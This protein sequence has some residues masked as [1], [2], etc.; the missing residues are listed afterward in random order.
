MANGYAPF[1]LQHL[2]QLVTDNYPGTKV[3][4]TGFLKMLLLNNPS[5]QI[6]DYEKIRLTNSQGHV[7]EIKLWYH[8]RIKPSE[9]ST[10][11]SCDNNF[12]PV[13]KEMTLSA[14]GYRQL[15]FFIS[16]IEIAKYQEEASKTVA[17]GQPATQLMNEHFTTIMTTV[18]GMMGSINLDLLGLVT[19]GDNATTGNN[20]AV[21]IN[22]NQNTVINPLTDGF[23]RILN[24]YAANE[25]VGEP[26][27]VGNGLMNAFQL[28]K[29]YA[30]P[31]MNGVDLSKIG[32]YQWYYDLYTTTPW[33]GANNIGVFSPGSIGFVDLNQYVG[34]RAK[35]LG[36]STYFQIQLPVVPAQNDGTAELMTFDAQLKEIDC[37]TEVYDSN[38]GGVRTVKEG[39]QLIISKSYGLFQLPADAYQTGDR[40]EGN[41]GALRY[42]IT[43]DCTECEAPA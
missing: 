32:N 43:N 28:Q 30:S 4:P 38:Y 24:D 29:A 13:R 2:K 31:G 11:P 9:V 18:N 27:M 20:T 26:L 42:T 5:L 19:W 6:P 39:Y 8:P 34:F 37:P 15:S 33:G 41:N 1:L 21:S 7:K 10:E 3:T 12:I 23:V 22:I 40:L 16:D 14:T 36:N 17:V 25:F 35:K